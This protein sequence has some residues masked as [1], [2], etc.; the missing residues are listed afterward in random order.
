MALTC[1]LPILLEQL[2][3]EQELL[4]FASPFLTTILL[5]FLLFSASCSGCI[6]WG[7]IAV[8]NPGRSHLVLLNCLVRAHL[9]N[10][11]VI[12]EFDFRR[13]L[14]CLRGCSAHITFTLARSTVWILLV[15]FLWL[16][17]FG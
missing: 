17:L 4:L 15:R 10:V 5:L 11:V 6:R 13:A 2:L 16:V 12:I 3:L 8:L 14:L 7:A 1:A 9:E